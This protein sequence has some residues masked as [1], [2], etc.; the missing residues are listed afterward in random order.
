[1]KKESTFTFPE[2]LKPY[3]KALEHTIVP[4]VK[5]KEQLNKEPKIYES[6]FGGNPYLPKGAEYPI[7]SYGAPMLLLAQINF[8]EAP[9]I[10]DMPETGML[11]FFITAKEEIDY[12]Q[13]PDDITSQKNFRV[14][15]YDNVITE[16]A[17]LTKDFSYIDEYD[18]DFDMFPIQ[19]EIGLSFEINEEPLSCEDYRFEELCDTNESINALCEN[20]DDFDLYA[21]LYGRG[22][23]MGG[24][25]YCAQTDPRVYSDELR[26][27][28]VLLL[29][30]DSDENEDGD[31][32][33]GDS[34]V[35]NF[36]IKNEDL[37]KLNF[38]DIL[39]NW[40]CS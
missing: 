7:D 39:Y 24:Y 36:F 30:I 5:I 31:I 4:F 25:C 26:E 38:K 34:G 11:Q 40:D 6:K 22:H 37:K 28:D 9:S 10:K 20:D 18:L 1:L 3:Q 21:D 32:M 8:S 16:E 15:Y 19:R 12:G 2:E 33:F 29:Q 23:K 27:Y 14:I 17:Q 35:A 13:D